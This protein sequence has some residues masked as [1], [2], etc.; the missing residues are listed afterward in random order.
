MGEVIAHYIFRLADGEHVRAPIRERFEIAAVPTPWGGFPFLALPD[1]KEELIPR[2]AGEWGLLGARQ[3]GA[4]RLDARVY[5]V[6]GV[7]E[8]VSRGS[9]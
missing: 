9:D 1:R 5:L 4:Y 6:V 3:V 2:A 8:S 7:E